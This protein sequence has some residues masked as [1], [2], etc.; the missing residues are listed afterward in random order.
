MRQTSMSNP[1]ANAMEQLE[2]AN[3]VRRFADDF[4]AVMRLPQREIRATIPLRMDDRSL[5]VI[6]AYRVQYQNARGPYKGG[7]RFHPQTDI[8]EVKALAFWMA[9]KC[10]VVGLSMGGGK[11]GATIDPKQLSVAESERLAR[12]WVRA[13][14]DVIGPHKDVPAPDVNTNAQIMAWMSD[15]FALL[16][17]DRTG[18]TFTGKPIPLGGSE[19]RETATAQGGLCVFDALRARL[20][21]PSSCKIAI[22]GMG[23]VGGHA[24]RLWHEVGHAV[25]A[26]SDSRGAVY[27]ERGLDVPALLAYKKQTGSVVG[28]PHTDAMEERDLLA[29]PCDLLIPAAMENQI[30]EAN[31]GGIRAKAI[32]ELANGPI[33]PAADEILFQRS[34]PVIPDILANAGGVTVSMYEWEQNLRGEHWSAMVVNE[35]LKRQMETAAE[36]VYAVAE[37][38]QTDL[39]RGAFLLALERIETAWR[40]RQ[41]EAVGER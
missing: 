26:V 5:R 2:R 8:D 11:G 40:T 14:A 39:R 25:T 13:F 30:T 23:N 37:K 20:G 35:K 10:A 17:G 15:E 7:I 12:G 6:E 16:T 3:T 9:L 28:Y 32:L 24:A 1:F 41:A 27:D 22:Q 31:A 21:L 36:E 33:T 19:G 38:E 4:F 18:A 29:L 34:I